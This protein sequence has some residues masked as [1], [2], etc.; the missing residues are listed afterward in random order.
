[1]PSRRVVVTGL[2]P[3]SPIGIGF[4]NF[5]NSLLC[6]R[7][8]VHGL[9]LFDASALPVRFGGEIEEFDA[10][11]FIDKKDRKQLKLMVRTIQLAVAAAR[12]AREDAGLEMGAIDPERL[13]VVLGTGIIPGDLN[14][15]GAAAH[16]SL[17]PAGIDLARWGA[18]GLD[19]IPPMWMLNHVP[20]MPACHVAILHDARGPNNTLVQHDAASLMAL[21][22][23]TRHLQ[24]DAVDV[25]LAGG[26]DTRT[27]QT[28]IV[29]GLLYGRLSRRNDDPETA[30]RPFGLQRDGQVVGEGAG[31][32]VLEERD[33]AVRRGARIYAEIVGTGLGF[34]RGQNDGL[35]RAITQALRQAHLAVEDLDHVNAA[36]NG[37]PEDDCEARLLREL[38]GDLPVLAPKGSFGNLGNGG[39]AVEWMASLSDPGDR[40]VPASR[41]AR[42]TDPSLELA[43]LHEMRLR[44]RPYG[45]KIARSDRGQAAA[46]IFRWED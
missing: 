13:G 14:D 12:L 16:A 43:V 15:L 44:T 20:N 21:I 17:T 5:R 10:R 18:V 2:G 4:T 23:A 29:R 3:V 22:E 19:R 42:W 27:N 38:R 26:T 36:A 35:H 25:V 46:L 30:C 39:S 24:R 6:E 31:V 33:H 37:G 41:Q 34:D 7:S 45:L 40:R 11:A 32:L 8:G 1:M 9:Q 28:S